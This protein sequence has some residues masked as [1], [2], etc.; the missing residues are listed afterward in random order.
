MLLLRSLYILIFIFPYA[1]DNQYN[2]Y[3]NPSNRSYNNPTYRTICYSL[4]WIHLIV[5]IPTFIIIWRSWCIVRAW[6]KIITTIVCTILN[7]T[8]LIIW[9]HWIF[10]YWDISNYLLFLFYYY[11]IIFIW[12]LCSYELVN[13]LI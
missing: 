6:T 5:I 2:K 3:N 1:I 8:F 9:W 11:I 10:I 7:I 13:Y 4:T 12:T